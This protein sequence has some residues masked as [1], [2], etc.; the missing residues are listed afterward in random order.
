MSDK[1]QKF[2]KEIIYVIRFS[3]TLR[4]YYTIPAFIEIS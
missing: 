1:K 4:N 2:A 3:V